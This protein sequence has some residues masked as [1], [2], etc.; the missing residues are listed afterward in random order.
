MATSQ[1]VDV[2]LAMAS[3]DGV[4]VGSLASMISPSS[5]TSRSSILAYAMLHFL[6]RMVLWSFRRLSHVRGQSSTMPTGV[7][8]ALGPKDTRH[9]AALYLSCSIAHLVLECLQVVGVSL[10]DAVG[11]GQWALS[12][13]G[14]ELHLVADIQCGCM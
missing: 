5:V 12:G 14:V 7:L 3:A 11:S 8:W 13:V 10:L 1:S 2:T 9:A 6:P 4:D